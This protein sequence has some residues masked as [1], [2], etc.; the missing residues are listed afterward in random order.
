MLAAVC[1][2][3]GGGWVIADAGQGLGSWTFPNSPNVKAA[4]AQLVGRRIVD[5][6]TTL[7]D[8]ADFRRDAQQDAYPKG[9]GLLNRLQGHDVIVI[10]VESYGR[11][12]FD[13][14][15]YAPT[16]TATLGAAQASLVQAGFATKSGWLTSPTAGGQS[17]LAHGTLSSGLWTTNQGRYAAMLTS[18]KKSLF[19]I[20]QE[21]GF[22]TSAFM[23]AITMAWPESSAMGFEH[24]FAAAD[25]PYKGN[26]FNWV[27]MPDQ[28]TLAS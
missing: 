17:W 27:T 1:A 22:R 9:E 24:I 26:R 20:A 11:A 18:G 2:L 5:V 7:A 8:L 6:R 10:Y 15:L 28:F 16:H 4:T 3:A 25:I 21:A 23:P 14:A 12:S 13:N 19:H